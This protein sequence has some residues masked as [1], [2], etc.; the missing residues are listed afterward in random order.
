MI[1]LAD[2]PPHTDPMPGLL[3]FEI[4]PPH[5]PIGLPLGRFTF[6]I[7][8]TQEEKHF[9]IKSLM[10]PNPFSA[11]LRAWGD[12]PSMYA[13]ETPTFYTYEPTATG[14]PYYLVVRWPSGHAK[15]MLSDDQDALNRGRYTVETYATE[16]EMIADTAK[17][18]LSLKRK[19]FQVTTVFTGVLPISS[20]SRTPM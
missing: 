20:D 2:Y 4:L 18:L 12:M 19:G 1:N 3:A 15:K 5:Q 6:A 11:M 16:Q 13:D 17:L 10:P 9:L 8:E 14:W 7:Y